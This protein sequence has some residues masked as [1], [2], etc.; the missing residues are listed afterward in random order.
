MGA[1]D[2]D[3]TRP[4]R[5]DAVRNRERVLVAAGRLVA[6]HGVDV[7]ME[8]IAQEAGLGIGTLYRRFPNK[9]ALVDALVEAFVEQVVDAGRSLLV[10]DEGTGLEDFLREAGRSLS[11]QRGCLPR[12]WHPSRATP[13]TREARVVVGALL[14][15]A[16]EHGRVEPGIAVGDVFVLLW[17]L[18][19]IIETTGELAPGAW[20]RHLDLHLAGLRCRPLP[21]TRPPVSLDQIAHLA[22]EGA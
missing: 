1:A 14:A 13:A 5:R 10:R 3:A 6:E 12:L 22:P 15:Q 16:Q 19:G 9:D 7:S 21:T 11:E 4:L 17:A 20:E 18:R 2:S 8:Q